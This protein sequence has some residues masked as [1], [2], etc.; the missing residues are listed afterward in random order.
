MPIDSPLNST[1][2]RLPSVFTPQD[3]VLNVAS[4]ERISSGRRGSP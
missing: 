1:S 4:A 3:V 2:T